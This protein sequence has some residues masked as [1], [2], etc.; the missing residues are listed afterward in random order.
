[1]VK[2]NYVAIFDLDHT[3]WNHVPLKEQAK[4]MAK[5][6]GIPYSKEFSKQIVDFWA[7]DCRQDIVVTKSSIGKIAEEQ[8]PYLTKYGAKGEDFLDSMSETDTVWLN[9][10]AYG[11]LDFLKKN[12]VTIIA[13]SDFFYEYQKSLMRWFEI[14]DFFDMI[15]TWEGTYEKPNKER[16]QKIV[17]KFPEKQF[18]YVGDSLHRDMKSAN[19]IKN[20]ISIWYTNN[21]YENDLSI[22]YHTNDL[23]SII[24][25]LNS[26]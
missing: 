9:K 25:Y 14:Y 16:I 1:M 19:H 10:G 24:D 5:Y 7:S 13:Y 23:N 26:R 20:C 21:F 12:G 8:I 2:N 6:L 22:D 4:D 17:S 11:L 18:I 3:L 15:C